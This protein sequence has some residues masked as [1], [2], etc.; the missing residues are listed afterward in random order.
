MRR[1]LCT[2]ARLRLMTKKTGFTMKNPRGVRT[3]KAPVTSCMKS[4]IA[5]LILCGSSYSASAQTTAFTY[6]GKLSDAGN[7]ANGNYDFEFKLFDALSGGVQSGSTIQHLSV[8]VSG[9]IFTVTLDFGTQFTGA[10]RFIEIAVRPAVGGAFTILTPRQQVT[11][12]PY[13]IKSL[14]SA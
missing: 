3:M 7:P 4:I 5:A 8:V 2:S 11:S 13:A 9:G 14:N 12:A 6:Q 10:S 1:G